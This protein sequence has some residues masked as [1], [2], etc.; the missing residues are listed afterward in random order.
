MAKTELCTRQVCFIMF[1][2]SA[3]GKLLMMPAMLSYYCGN[4]LVFPALVIFALQTAV[5]W[6]VAYLC[7]KTD[8]TLFCLA[9]AA[10][11]RV[12]S[13][14]LQW[15]FALFFCAAALLPMLAQKLF[16]Q[17]IFYDTIPS[18]ITF[19]PFF[20]FSVYVGA[21]GIRNAGRVA[22]IAM[23]V[24]ALCF[25]VLA[26]MSVGECNLSWLLPVLKTPAEGLFTGARSALYN[27][28]DG[29]V[30]LML[31]GRFR[32]NRGDCAKITISY[33]AA[34]VGVMLF[35]A[36]FYG[37]YSTLSPDRYFAIS[38]TALFFGPLSLVGRLDLLA[39]YGVE[40]CMLFALVLYIQLCVTCVCG[41]LSKE[42]TLGRNVRPAAAV[43]SLVVNAV[44]LALVIAFNDGYLVVQEF[45]GRFL[46]VAFALFAFVLP[47]LAWALYAVRLRTKRRRGT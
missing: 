38:Q 12:F 16:V 25:A 18:L 32:C 20:A 14:I 37:I 11:G 35:L 41:A 33:A 6:S 17:Y 31:M 28:A 47:P 36:L 39:V 42:Q 24:F 22:D 13:K 7:T 9:E 15:L 45:Y 4:D 34:G 43:S 29:A 5:V 40:A 8:K 19:V 21:K 46:W 30:M 27:F 26:V 44:L 23:P 3:A 2:Y 10:F 1:A